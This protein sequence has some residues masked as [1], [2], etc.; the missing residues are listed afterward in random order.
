VL[1][2]ELERL[3]IDQINNVQGLLLANIGSEKARVGELMSG[4]Y[5][6]GSNVT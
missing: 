6:L 3:G 1:R 4:G 2:V 5:Y